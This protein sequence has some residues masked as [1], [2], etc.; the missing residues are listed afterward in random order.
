MGM[1]IDQIVDKD[2]DGNISIEDVLVV[3]IISIL[4][5]IR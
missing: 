5:F 1:D 3:V 2:Q 4:Y